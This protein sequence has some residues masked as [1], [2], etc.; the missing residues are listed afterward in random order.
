MTFLAIAYKASLWEAIKESLPAKFFF[1]L[2]QNY[3]KSCC[4][5]IPSFLHCSQDEN[6]ANEWAEERKLVS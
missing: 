2:P 6:T 3:G 1:G 5:F 4:Y